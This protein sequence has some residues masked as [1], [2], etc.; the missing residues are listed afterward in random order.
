MSKFGAVFLLLLIAAGLNALVVP[1]AARK[2]AP[3]GS[4]VAANERLTAVNGSLL[5]VLL[6]ALAITILFIRPLLWVHYLVGFALIPPLALKVYTT[7]YRFMQYYR[8]DREFRLAGPPPLLLR[9]AV[10]PVLVASTL[11]VMGSGLELWAFADR[12]GAW[13][14]SVHTASAVVFMAAVF[15]HL[16][17]HLRRSASAVAED[18]AS[19]RPDGAVTRRSI[20]LACTILAIVLAVASMGY[21]SPFGTSLGG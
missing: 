14:L 2:S 13:W 10:A 12:F 21:A 5:V 3:S 20:V 4:Q 15:V 11:A 6:V 8:R 7:G 16:L 19:R 18:A 9:F 1:G 17:S